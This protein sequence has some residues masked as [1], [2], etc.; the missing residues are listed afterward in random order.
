MAE[1]PPDE[2]ATIIVATPPIGHAWPLRPW[3]RFL[4]RWLEDIDES[5]VAVITDHTRQIYPLEH[6]SRALA[7][8]SES[9][10][11]AILGINYRAP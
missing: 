8:Y 6:L 10:G 11:T 4:W 2:W 9:D 5:A 7:E 3:D 1:R